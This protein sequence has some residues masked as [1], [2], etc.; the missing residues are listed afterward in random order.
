MRRLH[1]ALVDPP[2]GIDTRENVKDV[3][4]KCEE[5]ERA[6]QREKLSPLF[7]PH[8]SHNQVTDTLDTPF[9]EILKTSRN[10]FAFASSKK[11][12]NNHD[13]DGYPGAKQGVGD[14][15]SISKRSE[16]YVRRDVKT[17]KSP[18]HAVPP[19]LP[20]SARSVCI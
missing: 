11:Q 19:Y 9:S 14:W 1:R 4:E 10:E 6:D 16:Y 5:E 12:Y 15:K 2:D 18:E 20:R 8:C 7:L 17:L 13:N 3:G